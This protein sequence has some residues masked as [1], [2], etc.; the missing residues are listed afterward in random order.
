M[1]RCRQSSKVKK[2]IFIME[3]E[4][5]IEAVV[6]LQRDAVPACMRRLPLAVS[7]NKKSA[8]RAAG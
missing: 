2:K 1:N 5:I 7:Y 6:H 8:T 4:I 3:E